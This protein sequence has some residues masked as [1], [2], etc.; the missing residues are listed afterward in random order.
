MFSRQ[1]KDLRRKIF[2]RVVG[3]EAFCYRSKSTYLFS[4][5]VISTTLGV[6]F[7]LI[8]SDDSIRMDKMKNRFG[9]FYLKTPLSE[10]VDS[11]FKRNEPSRN[12]LKNG[13]QVRASF[14]QFLLHVILYSGR[15]NCYTYFHQL[16]NVFLWV[17]S[18]NDTS[19]YQHRYIV[20]YHYLDYVN[21]FSTSIFNVNFGHR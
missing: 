10:I 5:R 11:R 17:I 9:I 1:L 16:D 4:E 21:V 8:E 20:K 3:I 12:V 14:I 18:N 19:I 6:T 7:C 15:V 13:L 2:Q